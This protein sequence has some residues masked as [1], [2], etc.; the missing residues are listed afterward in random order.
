MRGDKM[1]RKRK[2]KGEFELVA[3][4]YHTHHDR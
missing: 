3:E 2:Q 1:Q 4:K